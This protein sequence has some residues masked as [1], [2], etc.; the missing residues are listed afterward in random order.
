MTYFDETQA[1]AKRRK[2]AWNLLLILA[3]VIPWI[4]MWSASAWAFGN[5]YR[6]MHPTQ[7]FVLL[8]DTVGGILMALGPLFAWLP[9]AMIIGN[10][11][12]AAIPN[13]RRV[14][15]VEAVTIPGTDRTS[16]NRGLLKIVVVLTPVGLLIALIGAL[17]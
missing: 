6:L 14:L 7:D 15:D 17:V 3:V 11:L 12:V 2:S 9:L 8:P 13:A 5:L 4:I 10:L 1:R 16:A